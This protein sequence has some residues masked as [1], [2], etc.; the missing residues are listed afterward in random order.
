MVSTV[1]VSQKEP[2]TT[3]FQLNHERI[4]MVQNGE[5]PFFFVFKLNYGKKPF[6]CTVLQLRGTKCGSYKQF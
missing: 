3:I 4:W 5:T 1:H 2:K 6:E